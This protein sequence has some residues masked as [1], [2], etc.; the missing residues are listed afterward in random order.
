MASDSSGGLSIR[1]SGDLSL[2]LAGQAGDVFVLRLLP[3]Y[4]FNQDGGRVNSEL[5]SA[6]DLSFAISAPA[7]AA[8]PAKP[9]CIARMCVAAP[10]AIWRLP[11]IWL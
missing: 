11:L 3:E 4:G 5:D 7:V 9:A 1:G 8:C 2:T 10:T 6:V